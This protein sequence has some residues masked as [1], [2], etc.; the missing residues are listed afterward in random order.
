MLQSRALSGRGVATSEST[1]S[2]STTMSLRLHGSLEPTSRISI[3]SRTT[4]ALI[5]RHR[6]LCHELLFPRPA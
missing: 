4:G 6:L 5:S 3:I 2:G 1:S